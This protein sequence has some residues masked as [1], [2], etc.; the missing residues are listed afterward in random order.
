MKDDPHSDLHIPPWRYHCTQCGECCRRIYVHVPPAER[1]RLEQLAWPTGDAPPARPFVRINGADY[2]AHEDGHCVFLDP[3][4]NLCRI[5][6]RFG[7][8]AKPLGCRVYP[9]NIVS[10]FPGQRSVVGRFDCPGVRANQGPPIA[11][12]AAAIRDYMR[13]MRFGAGFDEL[14]LDGLTPATARAL[15]G[16]CFTHLLDARDL[17]IPTRLIA[18]NLAAYRLRQHGADFLNGIDLNEILPSFFRR[19]RADLA[20]QSPRRLGRFEQWRFMCLFTTFLRRD[21]ELVGVA[22]AARLRRVAT[23]G[24]LLFGRTSLRALSDEH[25]PGELA[26]A[27]LFA[28][29]VLAPEAVDW[30][31]ALDLVRL[32]LQAWQFLGPAFYGRSF[33]DG[34]TGVLQ[35]FPLIVA[36][37]KWAALVRA[38]AACRVTPADVDYAAGAIDRCLGRSALLGSGIFLTFTRQLSDPD[39]YRLLVQGLW[40]E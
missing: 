14:D 22:P 9:Y 29:P 12:D 17:P 33:F 38:P 15:I 39:A 3:A 13:A 40:H 7:A 11:H 18:T 32:R 16:A 27:E 26:A 20:R 37:A 19:I 35:S 28:A 30:R 2:L 8:D 4:T 36:A 23:L 24:R 31:L 5:H 34:L 6:G 10:T 1:T 25:P 21:D